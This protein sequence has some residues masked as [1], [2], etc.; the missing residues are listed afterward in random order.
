M[1]CPYFWLR[2]LDDML[3]VGVL[4]LAQ[5]AGWVGCVADTLLI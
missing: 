4:L 3:L 2:D 5:A 1:P